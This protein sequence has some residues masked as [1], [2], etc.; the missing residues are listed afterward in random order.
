[1]KNIVLALLF[2]FAS[3]TIVNAQTKDEKAVTEAVDKLKKALLD[4]KKEQLEAITA[5]QL[6]YG[7]SSGKIEDRKAFIEALTSGS[8]DFTAIELSEQTVSVVGNTALVRHRL[9]GT[10]VDGGRPGTV[11]L[12]VMLVFEKIKGQWLLLGRQAFKLP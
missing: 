12:G 3:A 11:K 7:H 2:I 9:D 5:P 10:S 4:G 1:M 8:S 6:S